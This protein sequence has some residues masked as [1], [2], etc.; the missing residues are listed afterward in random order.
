MHLHYSVPIPRFRQS[1]PGDPMSA[2]MA[3]ST[4]P[5]TYARIPTSSLIA[6]YTAGPSRLRTALA[7]LEAPAWTARPRAGKWSILEITLHLTDSELVG[8]GRSRL[9]VAEP[10]KSVF[11]YEESVWAQAFDYQG[12]DPAAVERSLGLFEALRAYQLPVFARATEAQW[13]QEVRHPGWGNVTLRNLLELY[14]DHS[15]RHIGQV[16]DNRRLLGIGVEL[17]SVLPE[18]LY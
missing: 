1:E 6:A 10:G 8:T 15:E 11:T 18:R 17:P 14:A 3:T 5:A 4:F 2:P 9:A 7:G 13:K 16:L 12:A